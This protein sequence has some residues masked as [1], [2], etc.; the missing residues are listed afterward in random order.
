MCKGDRPWIILTRKL[1][2]SCRQR[3]SRSSKTRQICSYEATLSMQRTWTSSFQLRPILVLKMSCFFTRPGTTADFT[4][5]AWKFMRPL[6]IIPQDFSTMNQWQICMITTS[7]DLWP[8]WWIFIPN[9]TA[10][11]PD[12]LTLE[13][14]TC[15]WYICHQDSPTSK[16]SRT[17]SENM[18]WLF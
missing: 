16:L 6:D 8:Y 7:A 13:A 17:T 18:S 10:V 1:R 9:W 2:L 14:V 5:S 4:S 11:L 15:G 12:N 3:R